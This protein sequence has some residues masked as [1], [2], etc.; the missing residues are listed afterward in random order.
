MGTGIIA[1]VGISIAA[2]RARSADKNVELLGKTLIQQRYVDAVK[3]MGNREESVRMGGA[4]GL[5]TLAREHK[6]AY[7]EHVCDVFCSHIR[8]WTDKKDYK[9]KYREK[10]SIEIQRVLDFLTKEQDGK[11]PP[12]NS[13]SINLS[14]A[15]LNGAD[16]EDARLMGASLM[17]RG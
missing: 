4:Y 6:K 5:Y 12:F 13:A 14:E 15:F 8:I 17:G 10:P 7:A 9:A 11:P 1:I 2:R 3:L 16:L